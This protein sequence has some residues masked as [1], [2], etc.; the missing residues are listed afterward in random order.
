MNRRQ[1][2]KTA[3]V[4]LPS[5]AVLGGSAAPLAQDATLTTL[6]AVLDEIRQTNAWTDGRAQRYHEI[7]G[8]ALTGTYF[9][10]LL[11]IAG[12]G[13]Q[14]PTPA[15]MVWDLLPH[16]YD[17]WVQTN[18]PMLSGFVSEQ[19]EK[20]A[21]ALGELYVQRGTDY[22]NALAQLGIEAGGTVAT[23]VTS[24]AMVATIVCLAAVSSSRAVQGLDSSSINMEDFTG[25]L[26]KIA[27]AAYPC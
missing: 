26:E 27:I 17:E 9:V 7:R 15:I 18:G 4:A 3:L 1:L 5:S 22:N 12:S 11:N 25:S 23:N 24:G 21:T 20:L 13:S 10:Q 2:I 19:V 8:G 14:R 16:N 6:H